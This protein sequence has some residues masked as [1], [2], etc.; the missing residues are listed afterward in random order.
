MK[1]Q[2]A[3]TLAALVV[4]T[5]CQTPKSSNKE[6]NKEEISFAERRNLANILSKLSPDHDLSAQ[7]SIILSTPQFTPNLHD[8]INYNNNSYHFQKLS[9]LTFLKNKTQKFAVKGK[10]EAAPIIEG[11][12]IFFLNQFGLVTAFD[13]NTGKE[14]WSRN[15]ISHNNK[16]YYPGG[17]MTYYKG[18]LY[19]TSGLDKVT[20]LASSSGHHLFER[21]IGDISKLQPSVKSDILVVQT[22]SQN[23]V[24]AFSAQN[25][26][27]IW[28]SEGLPELLTTGYG[29]SPLIYDNQ[30]TCFLSNGT[31]A[32]YNLQNGEPLWSIDQTT[33]S[34]D[35][36]SYTYQGVNVQPILSG[37]S[38]YIA[39]NSGYLSSID[40]RTGLVYWKKQIENISAI[41][42]SLSHLFIFT[43]ANQ[44]AAVN[45]KTGSIKWV[46][47]LGSTKNGKSAKVVSMVNPMIFN[48]IIG[49]P[50]SN[51]KYHMI[52][53]QTG[54]LLHSVDINKSPL[55]QFVNLNSS[56]QV[57]ID[58]IDINGN[59]QVF[60]AK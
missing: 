45:K 35:M 59:V 6:T 42:H 17:A 38:L 20:A 36:A 46:T 29:I 50:A 10:L 54:A 53:A 32:S 57:E 1:K 24:A 41:T 58:I 18:V 55:Y 52:N 43:S 26:Q 47:D 22:A 28:R 31:I 14:I 3:I 23:D 11:D 4:L 19:I 60:S 7:E 48:D 33:W 30:V 49:V 9:N 37:N 40:K 39:S 51:G 16:E 8:P 12:K 15:V 27:A 13:K 34:Q 25:G 21:K 2:L 5:S 56:G 44:V